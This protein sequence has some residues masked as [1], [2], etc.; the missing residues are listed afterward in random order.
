VNL[1]LKPARS[2]QIPLPPVELARRVGVNAAL[3]PLESFDALGRGGRAVILDLLPDGWQWDGKRVLDFGCG[4]GKVLRHFVQEPQTA[5]FH[6]CDIH[7]P[8]IEWLRP[9]LPPNFHAFVNDER[10]PLP[11]AASSFDLVYAMSVFTHIVDAWAEWL[12][13][14]HRIL[15]PDGTLIASFLGRGMCEALTGRPWEPDSA[16]MHVLLYGQPWD[17][18]GPNVLLAP[19]WIREH[20]GRAFDI[21]DVDDREPGHGLIVARKR[22]ETR[23]TP[24][25]LERPAEDDPRELAALRE[26]VR[27][28]RQEVTELRSASVGLTA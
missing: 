28:L 21:V 13:E 18:G 1:R 6:G 19:W 5:E 26:Q 23:I 17:L 24:D 27:Q 2:S 11:L 4:P 7:A 3:D 25:E 15:K 22:D 10:P 16:G 14:L 20:W 9:H 8:S 12:I